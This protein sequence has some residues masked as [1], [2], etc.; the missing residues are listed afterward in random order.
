[1]N[2]MSKEVTSETSI[3]SKVRCNIPI[4]Y[5]DLVR[6]R[7]MSADP[8]KNYNWGRKLGDLSRNTKTEISKQFSNFH[9]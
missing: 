2:S 9:I 5:Q 8:F 7:K 6:E 3:K 4:D 1:M